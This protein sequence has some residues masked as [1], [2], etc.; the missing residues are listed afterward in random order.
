MEKSDSKRKKTQVKE[1][2]KQ[3]KQKELGQMSDI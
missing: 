2:H 1:K 3:Y